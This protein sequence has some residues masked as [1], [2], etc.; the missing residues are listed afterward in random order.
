MEWYEKD[1]VEASD[2][3]DMQQGVTDAEEAQAKAWKEYQHAIAQVP[4]LEQVYES[5]K[6]DA[7]CAREELSQM[8]ER[9]REENPDQL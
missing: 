7:Q 8:K 4:I 2:L 3:L 1:K 6:W 9:I 5:R